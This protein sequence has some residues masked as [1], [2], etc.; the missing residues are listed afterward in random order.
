MASETED[1]DIDPDD[2]DPDLS[3]DVCDRLTLAEA[4]RL[5]I[6][7]LLPV[8]QATTREPHPDPKVRHTINRLT[9]AAAERLI[10]ISQ[11][12]LPGDGF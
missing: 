11:S 10:R 5:M 7:A 8:I 2:G 3:G 9:E 4:E 1:L 12:D 6:R